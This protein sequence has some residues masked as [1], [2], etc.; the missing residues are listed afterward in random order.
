MESYSSPVQ[1]LYDASGYP[2]PTQGVYH[3]PPSTPVSPPPLTLQ[4]QPPWY[5]QGDLSMMGSPTSSSY[6]AQQTFADAYGYYNPLQLYAKG[7]GACGSCGARGN[8]GPYEG[9]LW[10]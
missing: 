9:Q 6:S 3:M 10:T 7:S 8:V 1:I 2:T 4:F 5:W